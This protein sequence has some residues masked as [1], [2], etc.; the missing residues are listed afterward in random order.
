M[1]YLPKEIQ[2]YGH[3]QKESF[4]EKSIRFAR[5][6]KKTTEPE[7]TSRTAH[8]YTSKRLRRNTVV[9][10]GQVKLKSS[11]VE[12]NKFAS[13]A[14]QAGYF[15]HCYCYYRNKISATSKRFISDW[16]ISCP[17]RN[18]KSKNSQ[19]KACKTTSC[20]SFEN[21]GRF[22]PSPSPSPSPQKKKP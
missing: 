15:F 2:R 9:V 10:T 14:V 6:K 4:V 22:P 8:F 12:A 20:R 21:S 18:S 3:K 5:Q 1:N 11:Q 7:T 17:I 19:L 16:L 13:K